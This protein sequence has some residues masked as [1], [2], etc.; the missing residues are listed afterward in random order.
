MRAGFSVASPDPGT[1]GYKK[2][3]GR[4]RRQEL[5]QQLQHQAGWLWLPNEVVV[6]CEADDNAFDALI[7]ALV[8][9]VAACGLGD[10]IPDESRALAER[11][12]WIALPKSGSL[13]QLAEA[14][15]VLVSRVER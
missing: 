5:V 3:K 14:K 11:E 15:P 10:A 13:R 9:R 12:G 6:Q 7:A 1:V 2:K 4:A 8:T